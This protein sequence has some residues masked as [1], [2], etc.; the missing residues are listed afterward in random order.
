MEKLDLPAAGVEA[1]EHGIVVNRH[2]ETTA[3]GIYAAGD[4]T[5]LYPFTHVAAYQARIAAD[6]ATGNRARANYRVVPWVIFTDPEIAHVGRTE[7]E[8]RAWHGDEIHIVRLPYTAIDRAVIERQPCGLIKVIVGK[9]PVI[10]YALGGGEILSAYL[11]GPRAGELLH[12]FVLSMQSRTFS[13][14]L[15]Q[16]IH[17]YPTMSMGV[18]QAAGLLF[19]AGRAT[20]DPREGLQTTD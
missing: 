16:A 17:A 7:A 19:P 6:N 15:A 12:E 18:Q 2:L 1:G 10:G 9:K 14:R 4:G 11:V 13:G 3:E 5:G 8:A 20:V